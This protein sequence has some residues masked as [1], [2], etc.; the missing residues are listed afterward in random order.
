MPN[1]KIEIKKPVRVNDILAENRTA[2]RLELNDLYLQVVCETT[3]TDVVELMSEQELK[4]L[5]CIRLLEFWIIGHHHN[6]A[7][8]IQKTMQLTGVGRRT[9]YDY[10]KRYN[11]EP[12]IG[13]QHG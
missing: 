10:I 8:V 1:I 9:L 5:L 7:F 3:C 4:R 6:K 13:V 11:I 12:K 2:T